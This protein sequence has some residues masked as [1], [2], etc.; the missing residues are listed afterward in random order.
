MTVS[1][2]NLPNKLNRPRSAFKTLVRARLYQQIDQSLEKSVTTIVAPAGFGKT[3]LLAGWAAQCPTKTAWLSLDANDNHLP[4]FVRYLA[5]AIETHFTTSCRETLSLVEGLY[6][7]TLAQLTDSLLGEIGDLPESFILILDDYHEIINQDIHTLI[8]SL[9][10]QLPGRLHLIIGSRG[11]PLL[12][13]ARWRLNGQ[14]G[15]IRA[16]DLRFTLMEGHAL[17]QLLLGME[18]PPSANEA[19]AA[20]TEGW[21]AGLRL[22]ALSLRGQADLNALPRDFLGHHRYIMDYLMEEV[23]A[24]QTPGL[25]TL[26]LK[27]SIL[28]WMSEPLLTALTSADI[29]IDTERESAAVPASLQQMF[30]AG[31]FVELV[32][33]YEGAY[34][35]HDLFH[36][37]LRQRLAEQAPPQAIAALHH[38]ASCW[39]EKNGYFE[40]A[41]RHA[42]ASGEPLAAARLVERQIHPLLN[43]EA[44]RQL[45]VLLN[46]LP[47]QQREE[48][49]PLL[50]AQAWI[51]HF[52]QRLNAIPPLLTRADHLLQTAEDLPEE[53]LRL[54]QGDVLT[55]RSQQM[56][57]QNQP[58]EGRD[59]A[60]QAVNILAPADHFV[61]GLALY[62]ASLCL[63]KIG[64]T[65]EAIRLLREQLER[66]TPASI[67]ADMRCLLG[68]CVI[69][70]DVLE[71]EQVQ[72]AA[73]IMLQQAEA[74]GFLISE[75]W[76]HYFLGRTHYEVN[77][78]ATAQFHFLSGVSLRHRSN[79]MCAHESLVGLA[80]TY[81]AQGQWSRAAETVETL[82]EFDSLPLSI[83]RLVRARSLQARLAILRDDSDSAQ[84]WLQHS[85][86][87]SIF[88][89]TPLIEITTA[90]RLK[91]LLTQGTS[92]AA[93]QALELARQLQKD[94]ESISSDYRLIQVITLQALALAAVDDEEHALNVLKQALEL[95]Q[96]SGLIRTFI[97]FG[98]ALGTLLR[99]LLASGLVTRQGTV[100][101]LTQLLAAF[102]IVADA[103]SNRHTAVNDSLVEPLTARE[104]QVLELLAQRLTDREIAETLVISPFTVRRHVQNISEK[105]GKRG[106]RTVVNHARRLGLI[107]AVDDLTPPTYSA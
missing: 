26:L 45:E 51:M 76:A 62:Y 65:D 71:I 50:I 75:A 81:A 72:S 93:Q 84:H 97:D 80:L 22:T 89:H 21:A 48:R 19:I 43:Q 86:P 38:E 10:E 40:D 6:V 107:P 66:S 39:L 91:A 20:R 12:P 101:Y 9:I 64:E 13:L 16:S 67:S 73:R 56:H 28:N 58:Q 36:D 54:W 4:T 41:V 98:P 37:L 103:A 14:L 77:D 2:N 42:L 53:E 15:E 61:R 7:P 63:H 18:I 83:E 27:S 104:M 49:A 95:G 34:R 29:P 44:K 90:T 87:V 11:V 47:Q 55:L 30:R 1:S 35:Y 69:Q 60:M 57:W 102:P 59:L 74:S 96:P 106:R 94:A 85:D 88:F 8:T 33:E 46:M 31:L 24:Q 52:E 70:Q 23:F 25:Q 99:R 3:V 79:G 78:L 105:I 92:T 17:L 100:A 68:L 82:I 5:L 32:S